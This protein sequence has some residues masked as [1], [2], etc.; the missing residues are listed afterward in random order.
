MDDPTNT[1]MPA[2][3]IPASGTLRGIDFSSM[4][5]ADKVA[6]FRTTLEHKIHGMAFS[7]FLDGQRPGVEIDEVQIGQRLDIISPYVRWIRSFSC[8]EGNQEI[9][10]L[11]RDRGLRTMVGVDIGSDLEDNETELANGIDIARAGYADDG[12]N[13]RQIS[14]AGQVETTAGAGLMAE[15]QGV[16]HRMS[17]AGLSECAGAGEADR[18]D[19]GRQSTVTRQDVGAAAAL[20]VSER[21]I[22]SRIFTAGLSDGAIASAADNFPV[23]D[24]GLP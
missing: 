11:A 20:Q 1:K 17:P 4:S 23:G 21:E 16:G 10:R 12:V 8:I 6:L 14:A 22:R 19:C 24:H 15:D 3:R 5:F 2:Y 9:A 7:P 13:G 18:F